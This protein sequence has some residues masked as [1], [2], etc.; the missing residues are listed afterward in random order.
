MGG[1][2]TGNEADL[3]IVFSKQPLQSLNNA[4]F[5]AFFAA[6]TDTQGVEFELKGSADV[7]ARTTIGDVP[8]SNIP[9]NVTSA[10]RGTLPLFVVV[11]L[12]ANTLC[13]GIDSFGHTAGL[14]NVS[15]TGSG[16]N[17]GNEFVNADI[18]TTLQN[19]SN[20][21]LQTNDVSLAVYFKDVKIG[22]AAINVRFSVKKSKGF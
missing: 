15:I 7:V 5:A 12:Y 11:Q 3:E 18:T 14:S 1:V 22:R 21:S 8:I 17:G 4:V 19:P 13:A 2:S 10:L 20:I 9:F 6:V 16:G